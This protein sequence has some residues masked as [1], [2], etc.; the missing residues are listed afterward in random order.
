MT[1]KVL[2]LRF[3]K[4]R[5]E[6]DLDVPPGEHVVRLEVSG[7]GFYDARRIRGT[8]KSG[9]TRHLAA[10]VGGLFKKELSLVWGS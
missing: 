10:R 4:G 6:K 8:F 9:E 2:A 3:R 7:D 1:K 5:T